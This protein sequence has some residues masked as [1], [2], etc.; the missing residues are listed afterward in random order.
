MAK[1]KIY[2]NRCGALMTIEG[3]DLICDECGNW[4]YLDENDP[5]YPDEPF[6]MAT[7]EFHSDVWEDGT[8][9]DGTLGKQY[10]EFDP[11]DL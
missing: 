4:G 2:C 10:E 7:K 9:D 1:R 5:E 8:N 11:E 3:D 6:Q